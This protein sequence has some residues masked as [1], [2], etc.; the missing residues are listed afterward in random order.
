MS[1]HFLLISMVSA[2]G[3]VGLILLDLR[4]WQVLDRLHVVPVT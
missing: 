3:P 4:T 2:A 1:C